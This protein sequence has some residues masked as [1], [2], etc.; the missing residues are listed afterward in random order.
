MY[1]FVFLRFHAEDNLS[2]H[3]SSIV[4]VYVDF[5]FQVSQEEAITKGI[6]LV[7]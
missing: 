6:N 3:L 5:S 1:T 7:S 4:Y 2:N